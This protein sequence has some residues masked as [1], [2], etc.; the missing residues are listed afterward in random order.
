M[1][2]LPSNG[3]V[4]RTET[5]RLL[6]SAAYQST[7]ILVVVVV[8]VV[9]TSAEGGYVFTLLCLLTPRLLGV[10]YFLSLTLSVCLFVCLFVCL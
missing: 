10:Y 4:M 9:V 3:S 1:C 7:V 8:V 6:G 2:Q 5:G